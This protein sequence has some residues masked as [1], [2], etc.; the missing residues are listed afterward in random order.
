[1]KHL[2]GLSEYALRQDKT[3]RPVFYEPERLIN[4]HLLLCG[5]SGSGKSWQTRRLLAAASRDG[6]QI[7]IFDVHEELDSV[8]G[9]VSCKYSQATQYG[10]NPLV[11]DPDPHDGGVYKQADF[12]VG[13]VKQVTTQFGSKQ[14]AALR[15][16]IIDCYASR[17]VFADNPKTWLRQQITSVE[18]RQMID[19]KR[20]SDLRNYYPTLD[21]LLEYAE[22]KVMGIMFGG[23]NK[24]MAQL[25][26][27]CRVNL[28]FQNASSKFNRQGVSEAEKESLKKTAESK[29]EALI[30][31]FTAFVREN[32]T[33]EP[34]DLIKYD[35]KEVLTSVYQRL[36]LLA[37]SGIMGANAPDFRGAHVRNHQIKSLGDAQQVMLTKLRL[38]AIFDHYK[39]MGPTE[40]GTELRHVIFLDEAPKFFSDD[41]D[42]IINVISREARKF[43]IGLWCAAQ[44]PTAFPEDFATNCGATI[45]LGIHSS[46]WKGTQTKLRIS[47]ETLKY[48]KLKETISVKLMQEGRSDPPFVNVVVPNPATEPGRIA[49][50][51]VTQRRA[52]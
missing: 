28:Q 40:T 11:L 7:D 14:E 50:E 34:K 18:R 5:T 1:M 10:Y 24:C 2:F 21:D 9:A 45:L 4:S 33:R 41:K 26:T 23:D 42:D 29:G 13:L 16:L 36:Q 27:V 12:I 44:Q 35:S 22:R 20:W 17:G 49:L 25:D 46:F 52:A 6:V 30:E 47:E 39:K 43:G 48:I 8:E 3:Q 15:N 37:S 32:P 51:Y 38:R 31:A 19:S